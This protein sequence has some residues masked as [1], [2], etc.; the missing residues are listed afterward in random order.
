MNRVEND[1]VPPANSPESRAAR[2]AREDFVAARQLPGRRFSHG[3]RPVIRWVKGDGRDDAVT[4]AAIGQATRLFGDR[5]DYCLCTNGI[6]AVRTRAILEW[7]TQPVEWWPATQDDNPALAAHLQAQG[8]PP[9]HFGYWWKWFPERVRPDAPE[10]ILD[11]DMVVT[12]P[13]PWFDAWC[14]G[15]DPCRVSQDD[16]FGTGLHYGR[17]ADLVDPMFALYSGLVSLP[18]GLRYMGEVDAVLRDRPLA[19]GHDG[20]RDMCEQGVIAVAFQQ[21]SAIPIPLDE[22]PF[23]RAYQPTLDHGIEGD[24]GR[25]WGFHFSHSFRRDN[26]HFTALAAAGL[27][28]QPAEPPDPVARVRWLGARTQW[29]TPGWSM[30]EP[31]SRRILAHASLYAGHPVLELGTSRGRLAA[32]LAGVGCRVTTID[33]QDRGAAQN[34]DGLG[35]RLIVGDAHDFLATTDERFALIVV[36]LHGNAPADWA[37]R[38]PLVLSRLA[39]GGTILANNATLWQST[40]FPEET[41]LR[42]FLAELGPDWRHIVWEDP[43]PGLALIAGADPTPR[44]ATRADAD[45]RLW[46][47]GTEVWPSH[48]EDGLLRFRIKG[49]VRILRLRSRSAVPAETGSSPGD[50][51]RLGIA[52]RHVR[53]T[54]AG[55]DIL[56]TP[57]W[58]GFGSGFHNSEDNLRWSD[59]DGQLAVPLPAALHGAFTVEIA[60]YQLPDYAAPLP[61]PTMPG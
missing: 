2:L 49:P 43:S 7:A 21:L 11:G 37:R 14:T 45:P 16:R 55:F 35:V 46:I 24:H 53:L 12:A 8:C 18:P 27:V 50:T 39:P 13:P 19:P 4:R 25:G 56:L 5:V 60:A 6:D 51:R 15:H 22:F 28:F 29:G 26:P 20:R 31:I 33:H 9:G 10:W 3:S 58:P 42:D 32:L 38:G 30:P 54:G 36:D 52:V 17:Y 48:R 47:D 34:L 61:S 41:G 1:V 23:A 57:D 59:G 44:A 40:E